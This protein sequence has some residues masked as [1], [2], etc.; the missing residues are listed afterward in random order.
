[1][2]FQDT[3]AE[4][5]LSINKPWTICYPKQKPIISYSVVTWF[6]IA[7]LRD[8]PPHRVHA[9]QCNRHLDQPSPETFTFKHIHRLWDSP[10]LQQG[11][12]HS[13][14]GKSASQ[15]INHHVSVSFFP[16]RSLYFSKDIFQTEHYLT[17]HHYKSSDVMQI[18][19][20]KFLD[21][22]MI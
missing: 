9:P 14:S 21:W 13:S 6:T 15:A 3:H 17:G 1:M 7:L 10:V 8:L 16:R 5:P 2:T 20:H 22:C 19:V 4:S 18:D 11:F 12:C